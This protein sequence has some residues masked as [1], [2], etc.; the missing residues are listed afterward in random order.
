MRFGRGTTTM[1]RWLR[2]LRQMIPSL[3]N[4][5]VSLRGACRACGFKP[6]PRFRWMRYAGSSSSSGGGTREPTDGL[7]PGGDDSGVGGA[8]KTVVGDADPCPPPP[9]LSLADVQHQQR[10]SWGEAEG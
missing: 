3:S 5:F 8:A 6:Q 9:S 7:G 2:N 1:T 10:A 4:H